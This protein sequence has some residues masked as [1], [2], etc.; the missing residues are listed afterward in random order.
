MQTYSTTLAERAALLERIQPVGT[1][2]RALAGYGCL[3]YARQSKSIQTSID[4]Q[5][6]CNLRTAKRVGEPVRHELTD[7]ESGLRADRP[8]YQELLRLAETGEYRYV[9]VYKADRLSRDDEEFVR[10][11]RNLLR[12]DMKIEDYTIG[13]ITQDNVGVLALLAYMELRNLSERTKMKLEDLAE[14]GTKLGRYPLGYTRDPDT[15]QWRP[16]PM[17]APLISEAFQRVAN[18]DR[19]AQVRQW[20]E[21]QSGLRRE[22]RSFR[23]M[24]RSEYYAGIAAQCKTTRSKLEGDKA[25]ARPK[26]EWKLSRHPMALVDLETFERVQGRLDAQRHVGQPGRQKACYALQGIIWCA[27]CNRRMTGGRHGRRS[28]VYECPV[29]DL[30]RGVKKTERAVL[31]L[32]SQLRLGPEDLAQSA[33]GAIR[34]RRAELAGDM[35]ALDQQMRE[36]SARR[37]RLTLKYG[38]DKMS[39]EDYA[40]AMRL[41]DAERDRLDRARRDLAV[42]IAA[43]PASMDAYERVARYVATLGHWSDLVTRASLEEQ[44]EVYRACVHAVRWLPDKETLE[45]E[46]TRDIAPYMPAERQQVRP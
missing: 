24:L 23:A 32:L 29:C 33:A 38:D 31:G 3:S 37:V 4:A 44:Q 26:S 12:M 2:R 5:L 6:R 18:G 11:C 41:S 39:D 40:T 13:P 9:L 16:D 8:G 1:P 30:T 46:W 25:Y 42:H 17:L 36:L 22:Q 10:V 35:A 20:F 34:H 15:G 43:L 45:V 19:L 7:T 28:V 21:A 27:K 14:G